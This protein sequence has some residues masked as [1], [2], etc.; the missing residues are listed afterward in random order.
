MYLTAIHVPIYKSESGSSFF[1]TTEW[2]RSLILLRNS[3][4]SLFGPLVLL[5]PSLP[6]ASAKEQLLEPISLKSDDIQ[7]VPGFDLNCSTLSYWRKERKRWIN[8]ARDWIRQSEVVHAGLD[9]VYRPIMFDVFKEAVRQGKPTIFVQDTDIVGREYERAKALNWLKRPRIYA[10]AY[11]FRRMAIK[12]VRDATLS[13]LKGKDL[14]RIYSPFAR[15]AKEIQDTSY[16][17]QEIIKLDAFKQRLASLDS[18]RPLR[19]VYCGRLTHRKGVD[20][21]IDLVAAVIKQGINLTFDIIGGGEEKE[22]LMRQVER[23]HI[24][25]YVKFLGTMVYG[26]ELLS[27]LSNYDAL[28]FT[29]P[30]EDTPRMI[31]DGYAAGLPLIGWDINYIK[32]RSH[33]ENATWLLPL[34]DISGSVTRLIELAKN[35]PYL[36]QLSEAALSAADYHCAENWYQRRAEWTWEAI[37]QSSKF[38]TNFR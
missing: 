25:N 2:K 9:D 18:G 1:V 30:L 27:K 36:L 37:K 6:I 15:N 32:E 31:F 29:P 28:L 35:R 26:A 8:Q 14:M 22:N 11:L 7:L 23:L 19:L 3:I 13:L 38:N 21:S 12:G 33:S 24:A 10:Y 34:G 5:A 20:Q 16:L 4:S 17:R